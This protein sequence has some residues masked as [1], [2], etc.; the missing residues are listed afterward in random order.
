M[1]EYALSSATEGFLRW[2]IPEWYKNSPEVTYRNL[3]AISASQWLPEK[4]VEQFNYLN[5]HGVNRLLDLAED[6]AG[7]TLFRGLGLELGAGCGIFGSMAAWRPEVRQ[8]GILEICEKMVELVIPKMARFA[9]ASGKVVPIEGSFN[10]LMVPDSS[11]DFI[12]EFHSFHHSHELDVTYAESARVL[13]PGG[14]L[15]TWDRCHPD[16]FTDEQVKAALDVVYNEEFIRKNCYPPGV[17]MT[18]RENGEHEYRLF[19]WKKAWESAGL[20]LVN[21][22]YCQVETSFRG[23]LYQVRK[24]RSPELGG[25]LRQHFGTTQSDERGTWGWAPVETTITIL[26]KP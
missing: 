18:R 10:E 11:I 19:E 24:G 5:R 22:R 17:K 12:L 26:R 9:N 13:K 16:S 21:M 1:E 3:Y 23:L 7:T 20:D 14:Y 15:I 6:V 4:V 2:P 8:V 25:W